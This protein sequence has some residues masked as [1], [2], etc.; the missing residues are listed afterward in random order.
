ME[1][2]AQHEGDEQPHDLDLAESFD[3]WMERF[4]VLA[5]EARQEGYTVIVAMCTYDPLQDK[6]WRAYLRKGDYY[7]AM[8]LLSLVNNEAEGDGE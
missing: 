2:I 8:G 6:S 7:A 1:L 3:H 4:S 5:E